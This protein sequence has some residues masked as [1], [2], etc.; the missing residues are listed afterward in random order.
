M[1]LS[2]GPIG[3]VGARPQGA[4]TSSS[5]GS[6]QGSVTCKSI[7]EQIDAQT[8]LDMSSCTSCTKSVRAAIVCNKPIM[9]HVCNAGCVANK[10]S[11]EMSGC[12]PPVQDKICAYTTGCEPSK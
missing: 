5:S 12:V 7:Q 9:F 1:A 6:T 3:Y 10:T 11:I 4:S 2:F 8:P